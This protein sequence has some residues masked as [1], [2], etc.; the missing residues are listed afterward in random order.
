M[1]YFLVVASV[2][3]ASISF[4]ENSATQNRPDIVAVDWD[5]KKNGSDWDRLKYPLCTDG[6]KQSPINL[7]STAPLNDVIRIVGYN[8][9]DFKVDSTFTNEPD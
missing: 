3:T 8:Y 7:N 5:Y 6:K 9:I 1:Q 4:A 2:L